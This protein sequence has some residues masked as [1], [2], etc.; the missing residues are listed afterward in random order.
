MDRRRGSRGEGEE[1][2]L[3]E[4][5]VEADSEGADAMDSFPGEKSPAEKASKNS[6]MEV[7][8]ISEFD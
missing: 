3:E 8:S 1:A 2:F 5:A 4:G 6:E 7:N